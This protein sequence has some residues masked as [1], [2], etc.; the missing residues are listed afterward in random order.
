[1]PES[2]LIRSIANLFSYMFT[3][4]D[5][6]NWRYITVLVK[7]IFTVKEELI[8]LNIGCIMSLINR[9]FLKKQISDILIKWISLLI[10][11]W[12]LRTKT[13]HYNEYVI[14]TIYLP[15]NNDWLA[16]I[17]KEMHI[18]NNLK[19]KMLVDIDILV[20]KNIFIMLLSRK[21]IVSSCDNIE[22]LLTVIT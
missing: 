13:H 2:T 22:L 7:L 10:M 16:V 6:Q 8:C 9:S 17:I 19:I 5:F 14:L 11:I 21:A 1:L 15:N 12:E 3:D 20:L 4:Y 18:I